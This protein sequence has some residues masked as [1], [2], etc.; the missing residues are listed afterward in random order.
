VEKVGQEKA[1]EECEKKPEWMIDG[2]KSGPT[3]FDMTIKTINP[4]VQNIIS[5]IIALTNLLFFSGWLPSLW[6]RQSGL[7]DDPWMLHGFEEA[8][9]IR[10]DQPEVDWHQLEVRTR[11]IPDSG[12]EED[13]H[14][15]AEEGEDCRGHGL[16]DWSYVVYGLAWLS[17]L[18]DRIKTL[19]ALQIFSVLLLSQ[20]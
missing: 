4:M 9:R 17:E 18:E 8:I 15:Q 11:P 1:K 6:S 14:G 5:A 2:R 13:V 16:S 12:G 3:E 19:L 7:L 10:E 20:R